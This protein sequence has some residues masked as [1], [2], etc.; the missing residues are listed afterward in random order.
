MMMYLLPRYL[1]T[2]GN[3]LYLRTLATSVPLTFILGYVPHVDDVITL[4]TFPTQ[5]T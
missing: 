3:L 2:Q 5:S 4:F 1:G